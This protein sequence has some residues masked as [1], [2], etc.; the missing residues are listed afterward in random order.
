[1]GRLIA[2]YSTAP[3]LWFVG[4]D[5]DIDGA[6]AGSGEPIRYGYVQTPAPPLSMYQTMFARVPGSAEMPS[7][8]RPFSPRVIERLAGRGVGVARVVL[9]TGVSSLDLQD[10]TT[11]S[12]AYPEPFRV[13]AVAAEAVNRT[14]REGGRVIAVGTTVVRALESAVRDGVV[15]RTAGFTRLVIGP[16]RDASVVD[17]LITGLHEPG[18]SHLDLL[19]A[20]GG[21]ERV[22][23]SYDEA[24]REEY[25]WHE[26]GD[27]HLLWARAA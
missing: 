1:P 22:K 19:T 4:F 25:L 15:R 24:M 27:A 11:T 18:T 10:G 6:M 12:T 7:A 13:P 3:R 17:G 9:H 14:R 8:A 23:A 16:G 2:P 21:A 5:G 20:I 26:F